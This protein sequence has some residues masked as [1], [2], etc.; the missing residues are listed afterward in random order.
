MTRHRRSAPT[1]HSAVMVSAFAGPMA[2]LAALALAVGLLAF[3]L[4]PARAGTG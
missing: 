4:A 1:D 2:W 3:G